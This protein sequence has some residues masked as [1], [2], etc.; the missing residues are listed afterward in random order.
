[1][2]KLSRGSISFHRLFTA[3]DLG[4][5][6]SETHIE[7]LIEI[8]LSIG[9]AVAAR[10]IQMPRGILLLQ[11]VPSDH[12]SG[13]IYLYDRVGEDFYLFSFEAADDRLTVKD[14]GQLF[15]EYD[16]LQ[17]AQRP[18]LCCSPAAA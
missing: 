9:E 15:Q 5:R 2:K 18:E 6:S 4:V 13:A 10:W 16:L 14:F 11:M 7:Q 17:Y 8:F 1:M 12:A 3:R